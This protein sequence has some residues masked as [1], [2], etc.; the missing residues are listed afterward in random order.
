[1]ASTKRS[2]ASKTKSKST[3]RHVAKKRAAVTKSKTKGSWLKFLKQHKGAGMG[4]STLA[5]MYRRQYRTIS[6]GDKN[7]EDPFDYHDRD[8]HC[9]QQTGL[10]Y[11]DGD[12]DLVDSSGGD[13]C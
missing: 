7:C 13:W 11:T 3:T 9:D 10:P 6:G 1:M 12:D 5:A 2:A 8:V 4:I